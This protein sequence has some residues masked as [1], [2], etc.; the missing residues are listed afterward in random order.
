MFQTNRGLGYNHSGCQ[1]RDHSHQPS[2]IPVKSIRDTPAWIAFAALFAFSVE[3]ADNGLPF[4]PPSSSFRSILPPIG[5]YPPEQPYSLALH[6]HASMSEQSGSIE[7]HTHK[8]DSIGVDIIWWTEHDWRLTN[9]RHMNKYTFEETV[10]DS[11]GYRWVEPDDAFGGEERFWE[12][13]STGVSQMITS[14]VDSL[15]DQGSKSLRMEISGDIGAP[16]FNV[17]T[18]LQNTSELHNKYSLAKKVKISFAVF[19]AELDPANAKFFAEVELSDHPEGTHFLRYVAGSLDGEGPD[20]FPLSIQPGAWTTVTLDL[21]QDAVARFTT[22]PQDA[23]RGEDD[24]FNFLRIGVAAKNGA[25]A[26]VFFDDYKILPDPAMVGDAM[27]DRARDMG[28]FYESEVPS[29]HQLFGTEISKF[30]AQPHLNGYAPHIH[31]VDYGEHVYQD[32]LY[33]AI[34]QIHAQDGAVSLNHVF[35]PKFEADI[36]ENPQQKAGRLLWIKKNQI[37]TRAMGI[38]ILEVGYRKRGGMDLADHFD[39]WDAL[40]GNS[41]FLTG[42]GVTDSHGRGMHNLIG[43]G[44]S[45][46]GLS[47]INNMCTWLLTEEFSEAGFVRAMTGGRAYFG[48]PYRFDGTVDIHTTDGFRMG[49]AVVTDR[50]EHDVVVEMTGA[51]AGA[52]VRVKQCEMR[53]PPS[54]TYVVANVLRDEILDAEVVDGAFADSIT[55][56]VSMPS[57]LRVEVRDADGKEL[58]F[59][60]PIFFMH[61]VPSGGVP[62]NRVAGRWED[63][64]LFR[65]E[66][67]QLR[68]TEYA[69]NPRV[70]TLTGDEEKAGGGSLMIDCGT[71]GEPSLISGAA[72]SVFSAGILTLNGF[73]GAGSVVA[74]G[75]GVTAADVQGA[76]PRELAL[77]PARPNPFRSTSGAVMHIPREMDCRLDVY[78]VAGRI[79]RTLHE[80]SLAAGSFSKSWDGRDAAGRRVSNGVYYLRLAAGDRSLVRKIVKIE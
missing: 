68:D 23:I 67:F 69:A 71:S 11:V 14:V 21:T 19:A 53:D 5:G 30:K 55:V 20:V 8:A 31:L 63:L 44:P 18:L 49:Q 54:E 27:L 76:A 9:F 43:W 41:I 62:A 16:R 39:L 52:Q 58:V 48:D 50:A 57:F 60:N 6:M 35:G 45:E 38:D 40:S 13:D 77:D 80:G 66:R 2:G 17:G 59:S 22:G 65:A 47:T 72:S 61:D 32:S 10:W 26:V 51:P 4:A 73:S 15:A 75:W 64:R 7:W 74:L 42:N 29:V 37:R 56:D 3:A 25:R 70:L 28:E 33:Y 34:D 46:L 78:D 1:L 79:V 36:P 12:A 24:N